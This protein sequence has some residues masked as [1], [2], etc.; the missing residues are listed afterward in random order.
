MNIIVSEM[1]HCLPEDSGEP[2]S[3]RYTI[4]LKTKTP[5][6]YPKSLESDADMMQLRPSMMGAAFK[7]HYNQLPNTNISRVLWEAA[8]SFFA[9]HCFKL[10]VTTLKCAH[11]IILTM[12]VRRRFL[13]SHLCRR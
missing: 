5:G 6:F 3:F 9:S 2:L 12:A 11:R 13:S 8:L 7:D 4:S 1:I 10:D